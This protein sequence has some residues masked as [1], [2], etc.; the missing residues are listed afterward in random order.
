M[1]QNYVHYVIKDYTDDDFSSK[2]KP[3]MKAEIHEENLEWIA[4]EIADNHYHDDP[5]N[6]EDF[7]CVIGIKW[8]DIVKWFTIKA[9]IEVEFS[10]EEID[11][12]EAQNDTTK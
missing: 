9:Q 8:N 2:W 7:E 1:N 11:E 12:T 10:V 5:C 4:E 3:N 6:P